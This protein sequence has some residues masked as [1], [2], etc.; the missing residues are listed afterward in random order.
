MSFA[1]SDWCESSS[2]RRGARESAICSNSARR[3]SRSLAMRPPR[4]ETT[5]MA[6]FKSSGSAALAAMSA[7][8]SG[9]SQRRR[10][11]MACWGG[12]R[13]PAR[14]RH[15]L[16]RIG[17]AR[18]RGDVPLIVFLAVGTRP[19]AA[20]HCAVGRRG[21]RGDRG[22]I[23]DG[24]RGLDARLRRLGQAAARDRWCGGRG[25]VRE[26]LRTARHP[27]AHAQLLCCMQDLH[28]DL[29]DV[30]LRLL[31]G[32]RRHRRVACGRRG[33]P[34][35]HRRCRVG[36]LGQ[37]LAHFCLCSSRVRRRQLCKAVAAP[38]VWVVR[39]GRCIGGGL[40]TLHGRCWLAAVVGH[41]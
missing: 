8:V 12:R 23:V 36:T 31:A 34:R 30:H 19:L 21:R 1:Q 7:V 25:R 13:S 40:I 16:G 39:R 33:H 29:I 5:S 37:L 11:C 20:C 38:G 4:S 24:A 10:A 2:D 35:G 27:W 18:G 41:S 22:C 9:S 15:V 28:C 17:Y 3:W 26:R 32:H 6:S 14:E